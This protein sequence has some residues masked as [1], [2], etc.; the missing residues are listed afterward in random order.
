MLQAIENTS[1]FAACVAAV[2]FR[3]KRSTGRSKASCNLVQKLKQFPKL[4]DY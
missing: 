4:W 3:H 2:A 1:S